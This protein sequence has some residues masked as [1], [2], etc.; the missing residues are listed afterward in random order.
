MIDVA[1]IRICGTFGFK[2]CLNQSHGKICAFFW[3]TWLFNSIVCFVC[4]TLVRNCQYSI[5]HVFLCRLSECVKH[6]LQHCPCGKP[7]S[8]L[9]Q[10]VQW[11]PGQDITEHNQQ[12][13]KQHEPVLNIFQM[14]E[15]IL[16]YDRWST[17]DLISFLAASLS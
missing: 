9:C 1:F 16:F 15:F 10:R 3:C 7:Q 5:K 6:L 13:H 11:V 2:M 17:L 14:T 4:V 8:F 12:S